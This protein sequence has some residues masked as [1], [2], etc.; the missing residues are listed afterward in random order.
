VNR[1]RALPR[2]VQV[3][4]TVGAALLA[5]CCGAVA[6]G[7]VLRSADGTPTPVAVS[8][9]IGPP[10]DRKEPPLNLRGRNPRR[11]RGKKLRTDHRIHK[12]ASGPE[13]VCKGKS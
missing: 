9:L 10:V 6:L 11:H 2:A 7:L 4:L 13:T 3:G 12:H 1:I 5:C 8:T